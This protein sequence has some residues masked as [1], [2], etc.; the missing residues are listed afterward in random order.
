MFIFSPR[1]RL[2]I[3]ATINWWPKGHASGLSFIEFSASAAETASIIYFGHCRYINIA[4]T[5]ARRLISMADIPWTFHSFSGHYYDITLSPERMIFGAKRKEKEMYIEDAAIVE[6]DCENTTFQVI[7]AAD[8]FWCFI[9]ISILALLSRSHH[10]FWYDECGY[11]F[12]YRFYH[13]AAWSILLLR[14]YMNNIH[15]YFWEPNCKY[16]SN[17][18]AAE[19]DAMGFIDCLPMIWRMTTFSLLDYI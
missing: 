6:A 10:I 12:R 8:I 13:G 19:N 2:M 11:H 4:R 7:H 14:N 16:I 3:C 18:F 1:R 17:G 15:I 5:V 9:K